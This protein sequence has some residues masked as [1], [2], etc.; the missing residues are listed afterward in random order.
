MVYFYDAVISRPSIHHPVYTMNNER[1]TGKNL[2]GSGRN[3]IEVLRT[4]LVR[5]SCNIPTVIPKCSLQQTILPPY[6]YTFLLDE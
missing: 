5:I 1:Q 2:E 3:I 4:T 6:S